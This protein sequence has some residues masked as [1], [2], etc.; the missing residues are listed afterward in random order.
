MH[1]SYGNTADSMV[2]LWSTRNSSILELEEENVYP[3][4]KW[5]KITS[6]NWFHRK[7]KTIFFERYNNQYFTIKYLNT[8]AEYEYVVG[9]GGNKEI[10]YNRS[11]Q[12]EPITFN[13]Q[14][15]DWNWSPKIALFGDLGWTDNQIL[16]YISSESFN[17]QIDMIILYG[18]MIYWPDKSGNNMY[19]FMRDIS[20][21]SGNGS[22]PTHVSPGNG[23]S[24]NNF[25]IYKNS[26]FMPEWERYNS[27]WHSFDIGRAHIIG[28][29]TEV[30]YYQSKIVQENMMKW[31]RNDL[32]QA[33]KKGIR[34]MRPWIIVHFHRPAYSTY[35]D[36]PAVNGGAMFESIL[37]QFG[38]DLVF[39]GHI[40]N[41][42]R[43]YPIVNGTPIK[44]IN[45]KEDYYYN[46]KAPV[47]IVSGNPGNAEEIDLF[48]NGMENGTSAWRSYSYGYTHITIINKTTLYLDFVSTAL[49][50]KIMDDVYLYKRA[51]CNFGS[52]C[53]SEIF[54][55]E[56]SL[57]TTSENKPHKLDVVRRVP[58]NQIRELVILY[59]QT[60]GHYWRRSTNWLSG[61]P[62]VNNWYGISCNNVTDKLLK[63]N[64]NEKIYGITVLQLPANN[65]LGKIPN[66]KH[67]YGTLQILDLGFNLLH[68]EIPKSIWLQPYLHTL[69][70]EP[71]LKNN[72]SYKL[73]GE[74]PNYVGIT[75]P[76]LRYLY[77]QNNNIYGTLPYTIDRFPCATTFATSARPACHFILNN[78]KLSGKIPASI[79]ESVWGEFY[80]VNNNFT[81]PYPNITAGYKRLD[82]C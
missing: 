71:K 67:I 75:L 46:M 26:F 37:Y 9:W 78:N 13:S 58:E 77:L 29:S 7:A 33:T 5:K 73:Q 47:Y 59:H 66:L 12:S 43:F 56:N 48:K 15:I 21:I 11:L 79:S 74:I 17:R 23:D 42:E 63:N 44:G 55:L 31:L 54:S 8:N 76:N 60:N 41:Q 82:P 22:I 64:Y 62:C 50:G 27:L 80:A 45:D 19:S 36:Y 2:I 38:V 39:S 52:E 68:G 34:S 4:I 35:Y 3:I 53:K 61:D 32:E 81:C 10:Q 25:S 18:D 40:H 65:I 6:K 51:S 70:L 69:I 49:G 20:K 14:K 72:N 1:I 16:P 28:I 30:F 24:E 57:N